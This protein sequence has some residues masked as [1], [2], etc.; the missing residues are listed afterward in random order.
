[1]AGTPIHDP[2]RPLGAI[3][4]GS[5]YPSS[6]RRA[7]RSPVALPTAAPCPEHMWTFHKPPA[8]RTAT[9]V[10]QA[11]RPRSILG[12]FPSKPREE[13]RRLTTAATAI[14]EVSGQREVQRRFL[15]RRL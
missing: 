9:R 5:L 1:M 10:R 12:A 8:S 3:R 13:A 6:D 7:V 14:R 2:Y 15:K 11:R 4:P